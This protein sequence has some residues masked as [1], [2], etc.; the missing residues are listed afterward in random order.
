[1]DVVRTNIAVMKRLC[2]EDGVTMDV[3]VSN[4]KVSFDSHDVYLKLS[5]ENEAEKKT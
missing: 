5:W 2:P 4:A 1:M 3:A